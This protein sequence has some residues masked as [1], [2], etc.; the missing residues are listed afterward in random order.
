[1]Y[2]AW[3]LLVQV[4]EQRGGAG[5]ARPSPL[6]YDIVNCGR[7]VLAKISNT[8]LNRTSRAT[9]SAELEVAMKPM[10]GILADADELLCSDPGRALGSEGS[11]GVN[12]VCLSHVCVVGG[13]RWTVHPPPTPSHSSNCPAQIAHAR[14]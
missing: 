7:E 4:A 1:M 14:T 5:L 3:E 13:R 12:S 2:E 11:F 6:N 10:L 9:S 8:L